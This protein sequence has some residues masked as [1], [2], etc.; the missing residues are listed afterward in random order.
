MERSRLSAP[1]ERAARPVP[2]PRLPSGRLRRCLPQRPRASALSALFFFLL[3]L[4]NGI[5]VCLRLNH[6]DP[7]SF[8]FLFIQFPHPPSPFFFFTIS[9]LLKKGG[10][11]K[12]KTNFPRP[13]KLIAVDC[14]FSPYLLR[15]MRNR[16]EKGRGEAKRRTEGLFFLPGPDEGSSPLTRYT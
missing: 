1:P 7:P 9:P 10:E 13:R 11:K 3:I 8:P 16:R 14:I 6:V 2:R 12:A 5:S 4:N 15:V